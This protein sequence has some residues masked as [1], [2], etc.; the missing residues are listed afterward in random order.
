MEEEKITEQHEPPGNDLIIEPNEATE[1]KRIV[2][3]NP[4]PVANSG[5]IHPDTGKPACMGRNRWS[6][7]Y[8]K[9]T[10]G[11]GTNHPGVGRCK[12]HAGCVPAMVNMHLYDTSNFSSRVQQ[13]FEEF[14]NDPQPYNML[15]EL[16]MLRSVAVDYLERHAFIDK[17]LTQWA[18][19]VQVEIGKG[20]TIKRPP[21]LPNILEIRK[22]I[23]DIGA[24]IE[25]MHRI[26]QRGLISIQSFKQAFEQVGMVLAS[27][28]NDAETLNRIE[29]RLMKIRIPNIY[30]AEQL[31]RKKEIDNAR[32]IEGELIQ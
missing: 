18:M 11:A 24:M 30:R 22:L 26:E 31:A 1:S 5:G 15:N 3:T 23:N 14:R 25:R 6:D 17:A 7:T 32:P 12:F 28:V 29:K 4:L 8:C 27:E 13:L 21:K 20:D 19:Q 10:P 16:A 2:R 9:K